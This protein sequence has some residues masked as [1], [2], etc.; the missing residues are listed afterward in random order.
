MIP[1]P[2]GPKGD[3]GEGGSG[4]GGGG[5]S[6]PEIYNIVLENSFFLGGDLTEILTK[7]LIL[8]ETAIVG[9][10]GKIGVNN[11][12]YSVNGKLELNGQ[13]VDIA[14]MWTGAGPTPSFSQVF[15]M[16]ELGAG[17]H[18]IRLLGNTDT[19]RQLETQATKLDIM[20]FRGAPGAGGS[21]FI[22]LDCVN[23]EVSIPVSENKN[24]VEILFN[25]SFKHIDTPDLLLK[26][27]GE[28]GDNSQRST[29][30]RFFSNTGDSVYRANGF[31]LINA[32][33]TGWECVL[34]GKITIY[35][36]LNKNLGYN[37]Q[38]NG[39]IN[40]ISETEPILNQVFGAWKKTDDLNNLVI[41]AGGT[42]ILTGEIEYKEF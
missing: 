29:I 27:N 8:T 41:S 13:I 6:P 36:V 12:Q 24:G 34:N 42:S 18:T 28:T 5:S 25:C 1:G 3:P 22:K 16:G 7:E 17:T 23:N 38:Y 4:G 10:F 11:G 9:I 30:N 32:T 2:R 33:L 35:K 39:E 37:F 40:T 19:G 15:Y 31:N 21:D 20:V 26:P 14:G